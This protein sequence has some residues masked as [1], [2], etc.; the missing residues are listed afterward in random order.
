MGT[1]AGV[2]VRWPVGTVTSDLG[3]GGAAVDGATLLRLL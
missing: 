3:A 2:V 1:V